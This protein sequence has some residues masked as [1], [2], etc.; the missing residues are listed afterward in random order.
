MIDRRTPSTKFFFLPSNAAVLNS[1]IS[2]FL[3]RKRN[4][5]T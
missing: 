3:P 5:K 1:E 2:V 4:N